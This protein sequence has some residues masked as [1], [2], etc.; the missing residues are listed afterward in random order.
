VPLSPI[1]EAQ[2]P[3]P[4]LVTSGYNSEAGVPRI[5]IFASIPREQVTVIVKPGALKSSSTVESDLTPSGSKTSL[6]AIQHTLRN[7]KILLKLR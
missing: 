5:E 6:S 2:G 3:S 1:L 7:R 4:V